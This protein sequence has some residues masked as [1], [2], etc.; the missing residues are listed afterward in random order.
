MKWLLPSYSSLA[1]RCAA[2]E[3]VWVYSIG[4]HIYYTWLSV[5]QEACHKAGLILDFW[6][7]CSIL[8]YN[9]TYKKTIK[10]IIFD[11]QA[12]PLRTVNDSMRVRPSNCWC[13][14]RRLTIC[15]LTALLGIQQPHMAGQHD[16]MTHVCCFSWR[17][18]AWADCPHCTHS[19][20]IRFI[21]VSCTRGGN[22]TLPF[23]TLFLS[24]D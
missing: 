22:E 19:R 10:Y 11:F 5:K 1:V 15:Q 18:T 4:T 8:I 24:R 14:M 16:S 23:L 7:K 17:C 20:Q 13:I 21:M 9:R 3:F 2:C 6:D 12:K